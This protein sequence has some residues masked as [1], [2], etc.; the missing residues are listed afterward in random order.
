MFRRKPYKVYAI[1]NDGTKARR[2]S[3][4]TF[5]E[6]LEHQ[7]FIKMGVVDTNVRQGCG[8]RVIAAMVQPLPK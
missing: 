3:Y 7:R 8:R 2:G 5:A 1:Y 6:A 4:Q